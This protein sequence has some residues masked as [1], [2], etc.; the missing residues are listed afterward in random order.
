MEIEL[1]PADC[2]LP[3]FPAAH[4]V[5]LTDQPSPFGE[6]ATN[7]YA[8]MLL[9]K[10]PSPCQ[11]R[12]SHRYRVELVSGKAGPP[13]P[14]QLLALLQRRE[15]MELS[16][17]FRHWDEHIPLAIAI[18]YK[19]RRY[20]QFRFVDKLGVTGP[21]YLGLAVLDFAGPEEMRT[22]LFHNDDEAA[23]IAADVEEFVRHSD[24]MYGREL[25]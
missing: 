4:I 21:D 10:G 12:G 24:V 19:V 9:H 3:P 25:G 7:P 15:G 20:R 8:A 18:H 14:L 2:A 13:G 17:A 22:G 23:I 16:E 1:L 11:M 5:W 6:I